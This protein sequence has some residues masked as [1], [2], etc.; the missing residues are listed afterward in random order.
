MLSLQVHLPAPPPLFLQ[1]ADICRDANGEW[2]PKAGL[3]ASDLKKFNE[4]KTKYN[5]LQKNFG[6][7]SPARIIATALT[8]A[9]GGNFAGNLTGLVQGVAVN[10]LQSLAVNQVKHIA[11]SLYDA[12]GNPTAGSETVRAALQGLT[13]C[14]GGAANGTGSCSSAGAGASASVVI[15]YL[16]TEF[17]DPHPKDAQGNP[18]ERTLEDQQARTNLVTTLIGAIAAGAGLD[19]GS[20][21]NAAQIETENNDQAQSE[22]GRVPICNPA[23]GENCKDAPGFRAYATGEYGLNALALWKSAERLAHE[24]LGT[25]DVAVVEALVAWNVASG[26][27]FS[28]DELAGLYVLKGG[29]Q[30]LN[31]FMKGRN[32]ADLRN[33]MDAFET[34][35]L[36]LLMRVDT[37]QLSEYARDPSKIEEL[38]KTNPAAAQNVRTVLSYIE[39]A[40]VR[41]NAAAG[42]STTAKLALGAKAYLAAITDPQNFSLENAGNVLKGAAQSVVSGVV[43]AGDAAVHVNNP[44]AGN[45]AV[46]DL[47]NGAL[48]SSAD[49][50]NL[51]GECETIA[52]TAARGTGEV[53]SIFIPVK[54]LPKGSGAADDA[55]RT[56]A[57][58]ADDA[59]RAA[60]DA[61]GRSTSA[62][63]LN[64]QLAAE[65]IASGHAFD[66][67]VLGIGTQSGV[68]EFAD[69]GIQTK[70][71]FQSFIENLISNATD[72]RYAKDGTK[73]VI[74]HN[75]RTIIVISKRG[76]STA[77]R[78]D[79][80]VGW[81]KMMTSGIPGKE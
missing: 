2:Q 10:V 42:G 13:A 1:G 11:D 79:F 66:K 16:L 23:V 74:D 34:Q 55:A 71:Q 72:I 14:A 6:A 75:T 65:E 29:Q 61:A 12:N 27:E 15:N 37:K 19:A 30:G 69:L 76:E 46:T 67:H 60:D 49:I 21:T 38:A 43:S 59:G 18:I 7:N 8:G 62:E 26:D 35:G 4:A 52:C 73:F 78:P 70:Q 5:D 39:Y 81:D 53:A 36:Q 63:L 31:D 47:A 44:L 48:G 77:F 45:R 28:L 58:G 24:Q 41:E 32:F 9:A 17:L 54:Y 68:N 50:H 22:Q 3:S 20:A 33:Q 25:T 57:R 80:G 64:T 51:F 40:A 56:T